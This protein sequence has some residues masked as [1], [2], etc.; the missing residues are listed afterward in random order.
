MVLAA[1]AGQVSFA[2]TIAGRGV[3]VVQHEGGTRTTYEPVTPSVS[4]GD[5][6]DAGAPVGHLQLFGSHCFPRWCLHWGLVEGRDHYLDPLL[7]VGAAPVILLPL[8]PGVLLQGTLPGLPGLFRS[9]LPGTF[10][11]LPAPA[12]APVQAPVQAPAQATAQATVQATV[13]ATGEVP[14]QA[15]GWA[16]R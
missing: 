16:W 7:L 6:L 14:A 12:Q 3:V 10:P 2:G 11:S 5:V 8:Q 1:E 9:L 13:Q 15:R 4:V